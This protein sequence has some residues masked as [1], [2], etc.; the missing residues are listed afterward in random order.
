MAAAQSAGGQK[1]PCAA[2]VVVVVVVYQIILKQ[3]PSCERFLGVPEEGQGSKFKG[4]R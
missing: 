2:G 1:R 4:N 3:K